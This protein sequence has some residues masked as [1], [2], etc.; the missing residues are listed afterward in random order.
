MAFIISLHFEKAMGSP[1]AFFVSGREL[2]RQN[3]RER[4]EKMIREAIHKVIARQNLD[5]A[6]MEEAMREITNGVASPE[7]IASFVTALG[8]REKL[9]SRSPQRPR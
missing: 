3:R 5:E 1:V 2:K 4:R 7:Q 8:M 6:E 9:L